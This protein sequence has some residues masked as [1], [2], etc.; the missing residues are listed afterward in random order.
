KP[1]TAFF[2][3]HTIA[4]CPAIVSMSRTACSIRFLFSI[5]SPTPM[6]SVIFVIRGMAIVLSIPSFSFSF[7]TISCLYF[8]RSLAMA[9]LAL[10]QRFLALRADAHLRLRVHLELHPRRLPAR[11]AHHHQL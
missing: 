3:R 4:F 1:A 7:G 9:L 10:S 8:S 11:R 2:A 5:A 6:F